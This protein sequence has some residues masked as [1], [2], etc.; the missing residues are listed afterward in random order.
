MDDLVLF[1]WIVPTDRAL[2]SGR[3]VIGRVISPAVRSGG[4]LYSPRT[5]HHITDCGSEA[6]VTVI[7]EVDRSSEVRAELE[8]VLGLSPALETT[9]DALLVPCAGWYRAALQ[10]VTHAGLDVIEAGAEMPLTEY[11][12]FEDRS[13]SALRLLAFLNE[14]SGSYRSCC[15]TYDATERFWVDFFR[16]GPSPDLGQAGRGL[17]NLAG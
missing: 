14:V 7:T 3:D 12:A 10:E 2:A 16:R 9:Q 4:W 17:W 13:D 15:S 1:R 5:T 11:A 8:E 6:S